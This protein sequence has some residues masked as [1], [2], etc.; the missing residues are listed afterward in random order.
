MYWNCQ[1]FLYFWALMFPC[2][3][4]VLSCCE[5]AQGELIQQVLLFIARN[6]AL[7]IND[8]M[9]FLRPFI[10]FSVIRKPSSFSHFFSR[11]LISATASLLCS[12]PL[13]AI[14]IMKLLVECLKYLPITNEEVADLPLLALKIH[15]LTT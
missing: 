15:A 11:N 3:L 6:R 14:D 5:A 2:K 13:E 12:L 9:R 4:Q 8:V 7:E 1:M 10:M